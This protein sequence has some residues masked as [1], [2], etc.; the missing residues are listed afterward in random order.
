MKRIVIVICLLILGG[1]QAP[2][3]QSLHYQENY[4]ITGREKEE[5]LKKTSDSIFMS[6][7]RDNTK[8]KEDTI[9]A[10]YNE[11]KDIVLPEGRYR[12][13][14]QLT[15]NVFIYDEQESLLFHDLIGP[16]PLG[17]ESITVDMDGKNILHV[18]GF[19][20]VNIM[21]VDTVLSTELT[22]GIWEVGKDIK[23]GTYSVT[24][25]D[26]GYLE[27]FE[28]GTTP[29]L[30]EVI[31]GESQSETDLELKNGQK[32]RITGLLKVQFELK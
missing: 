32:L 13:T 16:P 28:Q 23:A 11:G 19:E 3:E 6:I 29:R 14:G 15:G 30:Y 17:V 4:E 8:A 1:C 31:G 22:P 9:D 27:V 10:I 5:I 7:N 12:I 2:S 25:N 20:Q 18:D 21:P 26:L 24:G